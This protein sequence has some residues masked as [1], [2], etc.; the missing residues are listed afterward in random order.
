VPTSSD[1]NSS[2]SHNTAVKTGTGT[3]AVTIA[4]ATATANASV[5]V[6]PIGGIDFTA[7]ARCSVASWVGNVFNVEC[8]GLSGSLADS[9]FS[10]SY[11]V[12]GPTR[13]QQGGHARFNGKAIDTTRSAALG[14]VQGCSPASITGSVAGSLATITLS[15]EIGSWDATPF[16]RA[17]FATRFGAAGYCKIE[18]LTSSEGA[19]STSSS[20][21][22]CYGPTGTVVALPNFLFTQVT[23]DA[24]GP[25]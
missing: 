6:S 18:S 20:T 4:N 11:S 17:S 5:M 12:T 24:A 16:Q 25:C 3:Y 10:L 21:V 2:G 22:R 19:T 13:D 7:N 23:S 9:S 1:Y 8:R 15:G 14:K